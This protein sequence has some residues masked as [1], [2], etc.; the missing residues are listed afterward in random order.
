M[1]KKRSCEQCGVSTE[2]MRT[3]AIYCS[4]ICGRRA[5]KLRYYKKYKRSKTGL[6]SEIVRELMGGK[7]FECGVTENLHMDHIIPMGEGG[8]N[9]ASNVQ[10][11]CQGCHLRKS[12]QETKI[13][14]KARL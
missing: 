8:L 12:M 9:K 3:G 7:C 11:L 1:K 14:R 2:G 6:F 5:G 4:K 13:S 10:L